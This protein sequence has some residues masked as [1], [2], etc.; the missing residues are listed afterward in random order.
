MLAKVPSDTEARKPTLI[1]ML[2][3]TVN[4]PLTLSNLMLQVG[5]FLASSVFCSVC[6]TENVA[7]K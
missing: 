6:T 3:V 1:E 2:D 5:P 4:T 7:E